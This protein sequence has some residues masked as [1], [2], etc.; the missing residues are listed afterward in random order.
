MEAAVYDEAEVRSIIK[1]VIMKSAGELDMPLDMGLDMGL[2]DH[3]ALGG[4]SW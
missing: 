3:A 1:A 2:S 4:W